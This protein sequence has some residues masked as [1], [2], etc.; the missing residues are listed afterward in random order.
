MIVNLPIGAVAIL[1][2][3]FILKPTPPQNKGLTIMQQLQKL[4]LLGELCL[5]PCIICL[6][7]ALQWGGTK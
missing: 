5:F 6:L 1:I 7:L 2:I 4:D 3:V